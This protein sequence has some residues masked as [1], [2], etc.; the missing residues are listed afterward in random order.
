MAAWKELQ[1]FRIKRN[2]R[3]HGE[4]EDCFLLIWSQGH[5]F[6]TIHSR[7][8]RWKPTPHPQFLPRE[9]SNLFS[10]TR[11]F[12]EEGSASKDWDVLGEW[13]GEVSVGPGEVLVEPAVDSRQTD[14]PGAENMQEQGCLLLENNLGARSGQEQF[15]VEQLADQIITRIVNDMLEE[16]NSSSRSGRASLLD[17]LQEVEELQFQ[18]Q[19][20]ISS[21]SVWREFFGDVSRLAAPCSWLLL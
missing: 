7:T 3:K 6:C 4:M 21:P 16:V 11:I 19:F 12:R 15:R 10:N 1:R 9:L 13:S 5:L 20:W 14:F 8:P 17:D 18:A 2:S